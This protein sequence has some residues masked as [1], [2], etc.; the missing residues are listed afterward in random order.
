MSFGHLL[1]GFAGRA[2]RLHFWLGQLALVVLI[3]AIV[4][5]SF[6]ALASAKG[7]STPQELLGAIGILFLVFI[8][9]FVLAAWMSWAVAVKRLHD[10]NKSG[11]W[12]LITL[13]PTALALWTGFTQGLPALML[14]DKS[15]L[16][17]ALQ[18]AIFAWYVIELGVLKGT[19]GGNMYGPA[20][21]GGSSFD[22]GFEDLFHGD[23]DVAAQAPARREVVQVAPAAVTK[24]QAVQR[25]VKQPASG[26]HPGAF[27][28]RGSHA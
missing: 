5:M 19:P 27:G 13:A 8:A 2:G 18:L 10:R 15:P 11:S 14:L 20:P 22:S 12:L 24:T 9:F 17:M 21:G 23:A 16:M 3:A 6:V 26:R 4:A 25:M 1:F 28:R 7:A